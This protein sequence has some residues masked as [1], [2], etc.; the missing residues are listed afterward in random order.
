MSD[1]VGWCLCACLCYVHMSQDSHTSQIMSLSPSH[2]TRILT[3]H[4][5][6]SVSLSPRWDVVI[7]VGWQSTADLI[8]QFAMA[9]ARPSKKQRTDA[10]PIEPARHRSS[11]E[12]LRMPGVVGPLFS[13]LSDDYASMVTA[14]QMEM[15]SRELAENAAVWNRNENRQLQHDRTEME[16]L[17]QE[18]NRRNEQL[19]AFLSF[20]IS[21]NSAAWANE[22]RESLEVARGSTYQVDDDD[23]SALLDALE[24]YET[25][26]ELDY[27][28][29]NHMFD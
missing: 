18:M 23:Y 7:S 3:R 10:R 29:I 9:E 5:V 21:T 11:A 14:L 25:D 1:L 16:F 17:L 2:V 20:A 4:T 12:Y 15:E 13:W 6:H 24:E 19:V 28:D 8:L 27:L 22:L 26:E